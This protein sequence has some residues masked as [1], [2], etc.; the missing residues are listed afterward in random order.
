MRDL[1]RQREIR[2][3]LSRNHSQN[4]TK[5]R[6]FSSPTISIQ[7]YFEIDLESIPVQS[8]EHCDQFLI[9]HIY[10][11]F[12]NN[13]PDSLWLLLKL[14]LYSIHMDMIWY[15]L[16]F[17]GVDKCNILSYI[18]YSTNENFKVRV[19]IFQSWYYILTKLMSLLP[20]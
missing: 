18:I 6:T 10:C 15:K 9:E 2:I 4:S 17:G 13:V 16:F 1:H 7:D 14:Q 20:F 11:L 5:V 3:Y 12:L 19:F 8:E